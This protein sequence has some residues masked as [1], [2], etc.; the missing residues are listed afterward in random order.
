MATIC[1]ACGTEN[2]A[3]AKFCIE[4]IKPLPV[5]FAAT[6]VLTMP[7]QVQ[8]RE[9]MPAA[10]AAFASNSS[11]P[12]LPQLPISMPDLMP[13]PAAPTA[14]LG[15]GIGVGVGVTIFALLV[16]GTIG[17]LAAGGQ[18]GRGGDDR[19]APAT[20]AQ[21]GA[22][23]ATGVVSVPAEGAVVAAAPVATVSEPTPVEAL[24]PG[25]TIV[26]LVPVRAAEPAKAVPE[27]V[28]T[29]RPPKP[30][31][32]APKVEPSQNLFATC[33]GMGFIS[34]SRCKVDVC[35]TG[36]NRQRKECQPILAQQRVMEEKR[37][38]TLSN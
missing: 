1:P 8:A 38:P 18:M 31:P 22:R 12:T 7:A 27:S 34:S 30:A 4:C 20:A 19:A 37:N 29:V 16:A 5:D 25:E 6:Q 13:P 24:A 26:P 33:A 14:R 36:A 2:R 17:W 35:E 3:V 9:E 15:L 32:A 10:L 21:V 11:P 23:G 28:A